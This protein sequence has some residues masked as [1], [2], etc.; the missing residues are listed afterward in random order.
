RP[1]DRIRL[2]EAKEA[3]A[4]SILD[5]VDPAEHAAALNGLDEA[6]EVTFPASDPVKPTVH[7]GP[8]DQPHAAGH[9]TPARRPHKRVP[10]TLDDGT[11]TE[12][13]H[14]HV[15]IASITSC[16]NTSNP[17]VM[18]A[19]GLLARKPVDKGLTVKPWV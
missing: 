7:S 3:F 8:A 11:Q 10:L 19:A 14:G 16:T 13:D 17:E 6:V 18:L 4:S 15:V 2:D 9:G 12:L 1:Q 5:Y